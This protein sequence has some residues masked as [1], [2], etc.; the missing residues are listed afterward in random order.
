[1]KPM[2]NLTLL[3]LFWCTACSKTELIRES[4]KQERVW[5]EQNI[6]NYSYTLRVNCYCVIERNGPHLIKVT[7]N[8]IVSV[9]GQPYNPELT[10]ILPTVNELFDI[11]QTK[12]TQKPFQQS[13]EYHPVLGYPTSVYFDMDERIADEEVGYII[14]NLINE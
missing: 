12:L 6:T 9:N 5:S 4:N 7:N 1:M 2:I 13:L 14:E 3:F 11:I 10:G 8:K